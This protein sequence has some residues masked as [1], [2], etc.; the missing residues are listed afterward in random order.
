MTH[1]FQSAYDYSTGWAGYDSQVQ[2]VEHI[3]ENWTKICKRYFV[4]YNPVLQDF[5]RSFLLRSYY[6][7]THL[8][9]FT[10]ISEKCTFCKVETETIMHVYW[11][12]PKVRPLWDRVTELISQ[13]L[14][15]AE[16]LTPMEALLSCSTYDVIVLITLIVKYQIFLPRLN[17]WPV[18]YTSVLHKLRKEH[19]N[20]LYRTAPEKMSNYYSFW[21]D[22]AFDTAFDA[23][24]AIWADF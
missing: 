11:L 5:A 22:L 12:C 19:N 7:N 1:L 17:D 4:V 15:D 8:S 24:L 10:D 13:Y 2:P 21:Q 23:E 14:P 16:K 18:Q 3:P 9:Q 20:H 6:L